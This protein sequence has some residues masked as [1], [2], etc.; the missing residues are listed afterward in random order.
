MTH[1]LQ[2]PND[3][4][5]RVGEHPVITFMT[6]SQYPAVG[7]VVKDG[8]GRCSV[9][10][11]SEGQHSLKDK[12]FMIVDAE[13]IYRQP[14]QL[15]AVE[16]PNERPR[17]YG[18]NTEWFSQRVEP[19]FQAPCEVGAEHNVGWFGG[20]GV[21]DIKAHFEYAARGFRSCHEASKDGGDISNYGPAR[22]YLQFDGQKFPSYTDGLKVMHLVR[23]L[24]ACAA[25]NSDFAS[26]EYNETEAERLAVSLATVDLL[27]FNHTT[28][29]CG[30]SCGGAAGEVLFD[31]TTAE[32]VNYFS[33]WYDLLVS[34]TDLLRHGDASRVFASLKDQIG[35]FI[36][37]F[38]TGHWSLWNGNNW[39]PH[40]CIAAMAWLVTFWHE[41]PATAME[42]L[43]MIN[44]IL[45]LH[46]SMFTSDGVY[47][48]GVAMYSYMSITGLVGI[49]AMQRASFGFSPKAVDANALASVVEYHLAS[50]ST[51]SYLVPFGD[52]HKKRGWDDFSTLHAAVAFEIIGFSAES[53]P[54]KTLSPCGAREYSASSYGSGGVYEDP[55]RISP[56]LL[57]LNLTNLVASCHTTATQPLGGAIQRIFSEGGYA[58]MRIPLLAPS[59]TFPCFGDGNYQRCVNSKPSLTDNIPYSFLALQARPNSYSHSEVDFGTFTWSAWGTRLISEYGY[60]TIATAVGQ[61]DHRRYEYIDNNPAGHN[62]VVIVEAFKNTGDG[63]TINFSQLHWALGQLSISESLVDA[64]TTAPE[65]RCVILDGSVVYGAARSDGW[66]ELMRRYAC[67]VSD[68]SF[69]LVDILQVKENRSELNLQLGIHFGDYG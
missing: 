38:N 57:T 18:S 30:T 69:V 49:A 50:M 45:W 11:S 17:L 2:P 20:S 43:A 65:W 9:N 51:D 6:F 23:R 22:S 7:E 54:G 4:D 42:V 67:P 59:N 60:G 3:L 63:K 56:H 61:W 32:P 46:R 36:S 40:L 1:I 62:T 13:I 19:F 52:S 39:T 5:L 28:W 48:E 44:D 10:W 26:C 25:K 64:E 16:P 33:T 55:W 66:M 58:S 29:Y 27:R 14:L 21:I 15:L 8:H 12:P 34:R 47:V 24:W 31:L 37:A 35:L 53:A 68:G 41:E